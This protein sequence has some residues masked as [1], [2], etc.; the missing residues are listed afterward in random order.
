MVDEAVDRFVRDEA[1]PILKAQFPGDRL[2][3]PAGFQSLP[4]MLVQRGVTRELEPS[5]PAST[6][7]GPMLGALG[8]ITGGALISRPAI[9]AQLPANSARR[10]PQGS[11]DDTH[12]FTL[13]EHEIELDSI[14]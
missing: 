3:R 1:A 4:H 7:L 11:R 6:A 8:V 5:V 10:P 12:R 9:A 2:R 13:F 14:G